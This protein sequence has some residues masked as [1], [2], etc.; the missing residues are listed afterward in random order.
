[1]VEPKHASLA[2]AEIPRD[3]RP[4]TNGDH[5]A[6]DAGSEPATK[7]AEAKR[8][9]IGIGGRREHDRAREQRNSAA[10]GCQAAEGNSWNANDAFPADG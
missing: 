10:H 5:A 1:M 6:D 8:P 2:V 9:L 4:T 7:Q 3:E